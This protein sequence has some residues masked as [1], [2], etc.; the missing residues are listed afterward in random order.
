M[1]DTGGV[2]RVVAKDET[3]AD[4]VSLIQ[5]HLQHEAQAFHWVTMGT[6]ITARASMPG[7]REMAAGATR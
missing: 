1:T 3:A 4:Q 5:Q 2:E 6:G 7:L